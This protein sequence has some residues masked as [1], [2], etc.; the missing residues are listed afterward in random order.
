VP[1]ALY[2][3]KVKRNGDVWRC[4]FCI[5]RA[6]PKAVKVVEMLEGGGVVE[7]LE[8]LYGTNQLGM[9]GK[10]ASDIM[11]DLKEGMA[12]V[13]Q[14]EGRASKLSKNEIAMIE[15]RCERIDALTPL[16]AWYVSDYIAE[17]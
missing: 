3:I 6:D 14:A 1:S 16:A 9:G 10:V 2:P 4:M 13:K 11:L 15:K 5:D 8:N 17:K 7:G 12:T